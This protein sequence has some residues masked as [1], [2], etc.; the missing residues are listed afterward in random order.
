MLPTEFINQGGDPYLDAVYRSF[1]AAA[2]CSTVR[3]S[4]NIG[5]FSISAE[6]SA[7]LSRRFNTH[8]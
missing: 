2:V 4:N 1:G 3:L 8:I 7:A 5:E 6:L